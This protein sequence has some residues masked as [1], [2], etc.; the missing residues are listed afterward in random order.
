MTERRAG[1]PVTGEDAERIGELGFESQQRGE[2]GVA[3]VNVA[4][5]RPGRHG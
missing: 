2:V 3:A 4:V 5:R 1:G